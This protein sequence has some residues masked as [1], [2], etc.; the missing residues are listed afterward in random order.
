[1]KQIVVRQFIQWVT[2]AVV[3]QGTIAVAAAL[4][5][6]LDFRHIEDLQHPQ[7]AVGFE[8]LI[9]TPPIYTLTLK[10]M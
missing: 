1:M 2:S 4:G 10:L 5:G 9:G 3:Q 7:G 8:A 6:F